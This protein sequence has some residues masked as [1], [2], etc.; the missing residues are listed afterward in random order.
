M[1]EDFTMLRANVFGRVQGVGFRAATVHQARL[2]GVT[3]WVRNA[4]NGSV[5]VLAQGT[6]DDIDN[7]LSWLYKGPAAARV[8]R[9]E[10]LDGFL[11]EKRYQHFEWR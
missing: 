3:G 8:D 4:N 9:V 5:E 10:V 11:D 2:D 7:F 1:S 6:A